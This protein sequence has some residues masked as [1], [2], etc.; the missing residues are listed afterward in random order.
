MIKTPKNK[1]SEKQRCLSLVFGLTV[2]AMTPSLTMA[3]T[4]G[5]AVQRQNELATYD[6]T[7]ARNDRMI[8]IKEQEAEFN[9]P[10]EK[11]TKKEADPPEPSRQTAYFGGPP[12]GMKAANKE[13]AISPEQARKDQ[14]LST[15]NGAAVREVFLPAGSENGDFV[16]I[17]EFGDSAR[18]VRLGSSIEGWKA[19][20][21]DLSKVEFYNNEFDARRTV[22]QVR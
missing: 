13:P 8:K 12:E 14:I 16:A 1:V 11:K 9:A 18:Q 15:L 22:Y 3:Q 5:E 4:I 19:V 20:R 6:H 21:V 17:I 10:I 7:I 2:I